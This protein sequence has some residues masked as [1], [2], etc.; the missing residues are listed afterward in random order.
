MIKAEISLKDALEMLKKRYEKEYSNYNEVNVTFDTEECTY[1][2]CSEWDIGYETSTYYELRAKIT[3]SKTIAGNIFV[4][5]SLIKRY[6]EINSD[7]LEEFKNICDDDNYEVCDIYT[8][9]FDRGPVL[10]ESDRVE[11]RFKEKSKNKVLEKTL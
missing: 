5:Y 11:I 2:S 4:N 3:F 7:L 1:N 8:N 10:D 6:D 9:S